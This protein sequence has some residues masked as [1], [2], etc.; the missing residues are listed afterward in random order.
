MLS[1]YNDCVQRNIMI[2]TKMTFFDLPSGLE[3]F[4]KV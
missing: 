4:G 2:V 1:S 3:G